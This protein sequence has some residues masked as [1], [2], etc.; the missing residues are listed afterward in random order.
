MAE[1]NQVGARVQ[2]PRRQRAHAVRPIEPLDEILE[3]G[4]LAK[5][6]MFDERLPGAQRRG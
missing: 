1:G 3:G 4:L 2:Q 5:F 6:E